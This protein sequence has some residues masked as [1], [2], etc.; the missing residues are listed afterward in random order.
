MFCPWQNLVIFRAKSRAG[1]DLHQCCA[2]RTGSVTNSPRLPGKPSPAVEGV[3]FDQC[4]A[5]SR[6]KGIRRLVF[7][8]TTRNAKQPAT[9]GS[10]AYCP[11][12]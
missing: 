1:V 8:F 4:A 10:V 11:L 3:D 12:Y 6:A 5:T 2:R 9:S 7:S